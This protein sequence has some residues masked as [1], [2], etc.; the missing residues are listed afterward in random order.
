MVSVPVLSVQMTVVQPN[1]STDCNFLTITPRRAIRRVPNERHKVI[2]AGSPSGMAA[3]PKRA[4]KVEQALL[5]K[6]WTEAN[7]VIA[8]EEL[9]DDFT[10]LSDHRGSAWYRQ[11]VAKNLLRAFQLE[12]LAGSPNALPLR[13]VATVQIGGLS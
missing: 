13:P 11:T 7:V 5:G 10:P 2:T 4:S 3:T 8:A 1:V 6:E 12:S 9:K